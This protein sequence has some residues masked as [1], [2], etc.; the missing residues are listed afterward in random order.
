MISVSLKDAKLGRKYE[1]YTTHQKRPR[2]LQY[3]KEVQYPCEQPGA[4]FVRIQPTH[5]DKDP[6]TAAIDFKD[7]EP[8][9][10][11]LHCD[12]ERLNISINV[13]GFLPDQSFNLPNLKQQCAFISDRYP[14]KKIVLNSGVTVPA[15]A[16]FL[17]TRP[18]SVME[19]RMH[20]DLLRIA[21][22]RH[23]AT[24]LTDVMKI[25][26][27]STMVHFCSRKTDEEPVFDSARK[28]GELHGS[29]LR[30][31]HEL[32]VMVDQCRELDCSVSLVS[33]K[34]DNDEPHHLLKI[35]SSE[36]TYLME[37][38]WVM[39]EEKKEVTGPDGV[40]QFG[41]TRMAFVEAEC[42]AERTRD[43]NLS[44]EDWFALPQNEG[45]PW[46]SV[47]RIDN[48]ILGKAMSTMQELPE[49]G[50]KVLSIESN[51]GAGG[52]LSSRFAKMGK[53]RDMTGCR[54]LHVSLQTANKTFE[55]TEFLVF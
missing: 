10:H 14:G 6:V 40:R 5:G 30:L 25:E 20:E 48:M 9:E 3:R 32:L 35:V 17:Y 41:A 29:S 47:A 18:P 51:G 11:A 36:G 52:A 26:A 54:N 24:N 42:T 46:K 43:V 31:A 50:M 28:G 44:F 15:T 38:D 27:L 19:A 2:L 55:W 53:E 1:I 22:T 7:C 23:G 12:T 33:G 45:P 8:G 34:M 13:V 4:I 21:R 37:P 49:Y 39:P 16:L